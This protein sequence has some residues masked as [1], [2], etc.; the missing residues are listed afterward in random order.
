MAERGLWAGPVALLDAPPSSGEH[1]PAHR[2][3]G[4]RLGWEAASGLCGSVWDVC[5]T[6]LLGPWAWMRPGCPCPGPCLPWLTL[7]PPHPAP[8]GPHTSLLRSQSGSSSCHSCPTP[9]LPGPAMPSSVSASSRRPAMTAQLQC[10]WPVVGRGAREW[11]E[12]WPGLELE[13]GPGVHSPQPGTMACVYR[14]VGGGLGMRE[15]VC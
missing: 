5:P 6:E 12:V 7:R 13:L 1:T 8:C 14:R 4:L 9:L 2:A 11:Q 3:C 10:R 15:E